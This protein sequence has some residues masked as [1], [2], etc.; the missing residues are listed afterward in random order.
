[1]D[2]IENKIRKLEQKRLRKGLTSEQRLALNN[3]IAKL[4]GELPKSVSKIQA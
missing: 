3:E 1:M 2:A 4:K